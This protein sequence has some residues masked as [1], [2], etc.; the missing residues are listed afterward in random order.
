MNSSAFRKR[1][2]GNKAGKHSTGGSVRSKPSSVRRSLK[3]D[4]IS[5]REVASQDAFDK[6]LEHQDETGLAEF[7]RLRRE[8]W[9]IRLG[10]LKINKRLLRT[11]FAAWK[12]YKDPDPKLTEEQLKAARIARVKDLELQRTKLQVPKRYFGK[13]SCYLDYLIEPGVKQWRNS[14]WVDSVPVPETNILLPVDPLPSQFPL[15]MEDMYK[16]AIDLGQATYVR[17]LLKYRDENPSTFSPLLTSYA[18]TSGHPTVVKVFLDFGI[19]PNGIACMPYTQSRN[20]VNRSTHN[21][22]FLHRA[23]HRGDY[24][25]MKLLLQFGAN[26][27]PRNAAQRTPLHLACATM[28]NTAY[29]RIGL[30]SHPAV[31]LLENGADYNAVDSKG[32][33]ALHLACL[34]GDVFA[35]RALIRAGA[36]VLSESNRAVVPY[37]LIPRKCKQ[38]VLQVLER[39]LDRANKSKEFRI[40]F[41]KVNSRIVFRHVMSSFAVICK[42]CGR[43]VTTCRHNRFSKY[44]YWKMTHQQVPRDCMI[45]IVARRQNK[46]DMTKP[47][48]QGFSKPWNGPLY[49]APDIVSQIENRKIPKG[50]SVGRNCPLVDLSSNFDSIGNL[51]WEI[52]LSPERAEKRRNGALSAMGQKKPVPWH[53]LTFAER[54]VRIKEQVKLKEAERQ[55]RK[56]R[57]LRGIESSSSESD[58]SDSDEDPLV[59]E[60]RRRSRSEKMKRPRGFTEIDPFSRKKQELYEQEKEK[61]AGRDPS[62]EKRR[63]RKT[64]ERE[65]WEDGEQYIPSERQGNQTKGSKSR[66]PRVTR[67]TRDFRKSTGNE[68]MTE[69]QRKIRAQANW[70]YLKSKLKPASRELLRQQVMRDP[71]D[72]ANVVRLGMLCV[73]TTSNASPSLARLAALLLDKAVWGGFDPAEADGGEGHFWKKYARVHAILWE[74]GGGFLGDSELK[75]REKLH[76]QRALQGWEQAL[77]Y[78]GNATDPKCWFECA[79]VS[80]LLGD[81]E[82]AANVLGKLVHSFPDNKDSAMTSIFAS[83]ILAQLQHYEQAIMYMHHALV[84]GAPAP[85]SDFHLMFFM[86]RLHEKW[87]RCKNENYEPAPLNAMDQATSG[88]IRCYEYEE[89]KGGVMFR[90]EWAVGGSRAWINSASTWK[91]FGD[92]AASAK[93]FLLASDMYAEGVRRDPPKPLRASPYIALSRAYARAGKTD[94][95][96]EAA[97]T[98]IEIATR[99]IKRGRGKGKGKKALGFEIEQYDKHLSRLTDPTN[100]FDEELSMDVMAILDKYAICIPSGG[101]LR[102]VS[103][104]TIARN[105][106]QEIKSRLELDNKRG[107]KKR[108]TIRWEALR[109]RLKGAARR[110]YSMQL[111]QRPRDTVRGSMLAQMGILCVDNG[112]QSTPQMDRCAALI[113]QKAADAGY[114]GDPDVPNSEAKF[115]LYFARAHF[116]VWTRDGVRADRIHLIRSSW[117]WE[118]ALAH[119]RVAC[120]VGCWREA[121]ATLMCLGDYP[122]AA[123]ML[124]I[125][126]RS[127]PRYPNIQAV[128]FDVSVLLFQLRQFDQALAYAQMALRTNRISAPLTHADLFFYISRIYDKLAIAA[129]EQCDAARA[130][131]RRLKLE[132][133][134]MRRRAQEEQNEGSQEDGGGDVSESGSSGTE[135]DSEYSRVSEEERIGEEYRS[136]A[137]KTRE[138]VLQHLK[139]TDEVPETTDVDDWLSEPDTHARFAMRAIDAGKYLLAVDMY[140]EALELAKDIDTPESDSESDD[141]T[142]SQSQADS[143]SADKQ[144]GSVDSSGSDSSVDEQ[145]LQEDRAKCKRVVSLWF[146]L[147][148]AHCRCGQMQLAIR[149]CAEALKLPT[150]EEDKMSGIMKHWQ[151]LSDGDD[152]RISPFDEEVKEPLPSLL[153]KYVM[154]EDSMM[155]IDW[156]AVDDQQRKKS[157]DA[158]VAS[159]KTQIVGKYRKKLRL[160]SANGAGNDD[161]ERIHTVEDVEKHLATKRRWEILK[162]GI[163]AVAREIMREN[164]EDGFAKVTGTAERDCGD[165]MVKLIARVGFSCASET[166]GPN[167]TIN[168]A[169][170]ACLLLA[171]AYDF[172]YLDCVRRDHNGDAD[173]GA[174]A[175]SLAEAKL[176]KTRAICHWRV[177]ERQGLG[178][179]KGERSHLEQCLSAWDEA[180]K[181]LSVSGDV[182]NW[183]L[184]AQAAIAKGDYPVASKA[185]GTILRSFR[186]GNSIGTVIMCSSLLKALGNFDQAIAYMF[187]AVSMESEGHYDGIDLAFFMARLNEEY[188]LLE[189]EKE[190]SGGAAGGSRAG[191]VAVTAYNAVFDQLQQLENPKQGG[192]KNASSWLADHKTWLAYGNICCAAG[193]YIFAS[194]FYEQSLKRLK[195]S[196]E[197]AKVRVELAVKLAK[198]LRKCGQFERSMEVIEIAVNEEVNGAKKNKLTALKKVWASYSEGGGGRRRR[199][200]RQT[201]GADGSMLYKIAIMLPVTEVL[202]Q[203]VPKPMKKGEDPELKRLKALRELNARNGKWKHLRRKLKQA[204]RVEFAKNYVHELWSLDKAADSQKRDILKGTVGAKDMENL[205]A[206]TSKGGYASETVNV[207]RLDAFELRA[208]DQVT[209]ALQMLVTMGKLCHESSSSSNGMHRCAAT[210]LQRAADCGF[211]GDG[212]FW[213]ML[214]VSHFKAY[215]SGGV[216]GD[217]TRL[218]MSNNAWD[219]AFEHLDNASNVECWLQASNV[220]IHMGDFERAAQT[221]GVLVRSFPKYS[222]LSAVSL[223]SASILQKVRLSKVDAGCIYIYIYICVCVL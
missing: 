33:T 50:A 159:A 35:I 170:G 29:M 20:S 60:S 72:L 164:L 206:A 132:E 177:Y 16:S 73:D 221:L 11:T 172:G 43:R 28:Q 149:A 53:Q 193:Q 111:L 10:S 212:S 157:G 93:L 167:D 202:R 120:D 42:V 87:A 151:Q 94:S 69:E 217:R 44:S 5:S 81:H 209:V 101:T 169:I 7:L 187:S 95:A 56:L 112:P 168:I 86:S 57:Q 4:S 23:A 144:G 117:G 100:Y 65:V 118:K 163:K 174:E 19:D 136:V 47:I 2:G 181:H 137:Y 38:Q 96:I 121:A 203:F 214:A 85:L 155:Q 36:S 54:K 213:K 158:E 22:T 31:L 154:E 195:K 17:Q 49:D 62:K 190:R 191:R 201:F 208:R 150:H 30:K 107:R 21:S 83:S 113:L 204:A 219:K 79:L 194:D 184:Y 15:T 196:R 34:S 82:S 45:E 175:F 40:M 160:E 1:R 162:E 70:K 142:K 183:H 66:S 147:A 133:K 223:T 198:C 24:E 91:Q 145:K 68:Y 98:A 152:D 104:E 27:N 146:G 67:G 13:N 220:R 52:F 131:R 171:K 92:A 6:A 78:M 178:A 179:G 59:R 3:E 207:E 64:R 48:P 124:G 119:V 14:L 197:S 99:E 138:K 166:S 128:Q 89:E 200:S 106:A 222:R 218:V 97:E 127:F 84:K 41:A 123:Q 161:L 39:A 18:M 108:S 185:Y 25:S 139:D 8:A 61:N 90:T 51:P 122:R 115:W 74:T 143:K 165:D 189:Q 37:E 110:Y 192:H 63:P 141:D 180:L 186:S 188:G 140:K 182:S 125:L 55:A 130:E 156:D 77:H 135:S 134:E 173:K 114:S 216:A 32:F 148:K 102:Q 199:A 211:V 109:D 71:S 153:D 9:K 129:D 58:T 176:W 116:K 26:V 80:Q 76:L 75:G 46:R 105:R 12:N 126:V 210:L 205:K 215:A 88:Y 103:G